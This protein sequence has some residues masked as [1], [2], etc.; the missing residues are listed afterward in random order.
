MRCFERFLIDHC[1]SDITN[2]NIAGKYQN[3]I[4]SVSSTLY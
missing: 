1:A 4:V 2:N 3:I